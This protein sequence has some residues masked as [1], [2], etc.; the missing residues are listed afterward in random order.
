MTT[1]TTTTHLACEVLD[2]GEWKPATLRY[3]DEHLGRAIGFM[4]DIDPDSDVS[5]VRVVTTTVAAARYLHAARVDEV[6][7]EEAGRAGG[8]DVIAWA[9]EVGDVFYRYDECLQFVPGPAGTV[10]IVLI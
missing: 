10:T 1:T 8:P 3:A 4:H 2:G 7:A 6:G 5:D 9:L